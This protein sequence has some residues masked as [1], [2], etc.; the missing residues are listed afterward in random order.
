MKFTYVKR[1]RYQPVQFDEPFGVFLD[2]I[3]F[4]KAHP[5][6]KQIYRATQ[7]G[8]FILEVER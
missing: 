4:A 2:M 8:L 7:K 1:Y 3:E 6:A 5:K